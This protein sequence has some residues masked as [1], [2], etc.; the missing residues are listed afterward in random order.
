MAL[1]G[2]LNPNDAPAAAAAEQLMRIFQ[3]VLTNLTEIANS[4]NDIDAINTAVG[5][6]NCLR[7]NFVLP[8]I[9]QV[10]AGAVSNN[11]GSIPAGTTGPAM[12]LLPALGS[13]I[14]EDGG[15]VCAP[16]P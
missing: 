15:V 7:C 2:L 5:R 10:Y 14:K 1:N 4:A 9:D 6:I 16:H 8:D 13:A 3:G 12:C 11:P